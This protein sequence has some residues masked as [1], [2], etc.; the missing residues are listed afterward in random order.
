MTLEEIRANQVADLND[1]E[2]AF[3]AEHKA[4]LT[5]EELTTYGLAEPEVPE[6]PETPGEPETPEVPEPEFQ[7]RLK[8]HSLRKSKQVH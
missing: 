5:A 7:R 8:R 6:T 1:E 4:E 3:L 2:K